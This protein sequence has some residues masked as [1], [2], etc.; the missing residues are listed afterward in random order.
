MKKAIHII[1]IVVGL[2]TICTI[3]QLL[4]NKY[5]KE[6]EERANNL[7]VQFL[8]TNQIDTKIIS[9]TNELADFWKNKENILC[10]F[11]NHKEIEEIGEEITK[12]QAAVKNNNLQQ[13][14]ESLDLIKFYVE[15]Y[16]HIIGINLQNIF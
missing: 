7:Y 3:E 14:L 13:Y 6:V 11:V 15:G 2:I 12:M 9:N 5:F 1:I 16:K 8:S 10:T 4:A